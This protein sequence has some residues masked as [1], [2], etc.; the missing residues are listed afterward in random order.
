MKVIKRLLLFIL[1]ILVVVIG[2]TTIVVMAHKVVTTND[3]LSEEVYTAASGSN[4]YLALM[5]TAHGTNDEYTTLEN[6]LNYYLLDTIHSDL[7]AEYDP[8]S[9]SPTTATEYIYWNDY[10]YINYMYIH[11]TEDNLMELTISIGSTWVDYTTAITLVFDIS[12]QATL[13]PVSSDYIFTLQDVRIKDTVITT[14]QLSQLME[15]VNQ[16]AI[17][18]AVTFGTLNLDDFT[19]VVPII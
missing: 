12:Y 18:Q 17:E 10:M 19:L 1:F 13:I 8:F 14:D 5:I 3:V 15:Y 2:V 4:P 9:D 11:I 16:D 7:N 6:M